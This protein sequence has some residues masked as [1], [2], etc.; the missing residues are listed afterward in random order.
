MYIFVFVD[1]RYLLW[2]TKRISILSS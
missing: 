2:T 1:V